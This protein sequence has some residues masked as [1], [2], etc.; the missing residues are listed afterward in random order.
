MRQIDRDTLRKTIGQS[1]LDVNKIS[2]TI[3]A[4]EVNLA[5]Q[6]A[7]SKDRSVV[8]DEDS[9]AE[10]GE[11][12]RIGAGLSMEKTGEVLENVTNLIKEKDEK[13]VQLLDHGIFEIKGGTLKFKLGKK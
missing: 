6:A 2:K 7:K 8:L 10:L 1:G 11:T 5:K 4:I 13:V 9:L 12:V 3:T